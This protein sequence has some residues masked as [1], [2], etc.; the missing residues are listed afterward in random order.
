MT[1][2]LPGNTVSPYMFN[3]ICWFQRLGCKH[4]CSITDIDATLIARR[5]EDLVYDE[6][7]LRGTCGPSVDVT[8]KDPK[9][10][11]RWGK[12]KVV[13]QFPV[14]VQAVYVQPDYLQVIGVRNKISDRTIER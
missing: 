3:A 4:H 10:K 9:R 8:L 6:Q 14:A 1:R 7:I 2:K 12:P 5:G 13:P 11:F